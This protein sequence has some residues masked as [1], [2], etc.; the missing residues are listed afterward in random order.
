MTPLLP[1]D[2]LIWSPVVANSR[3]NRQRNAS[4]INSYEQEFNFKPEDF[5]ASR[6]KSNGNTSWLDLCCGEGNALVQIAAYFYDKGLE[7]KIHLKGV[8]LLDTFPNINEKFSCISF[9]TAAVVNYVPRQKYDL[10]TCVHGIHYLGDKLKFLEN[11]INALS[12]DGV[13]IGNL[14]LNNIIINNKNSGQWLSDF[15]KRSGI[16][17]NN[18]SR[19]IKKEGA[20][21]VNFGLHYI[22]ADD[23]SGPNYTGQEAVT[24]YYNS[25][26]V[27]L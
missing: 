4:G 20:A 19:I 25:P 26:G 1:E 12:S 8:D 2:K 21:V 17:Y 3:M 6:I 24:S 11:A 18:K 23:T 5:L 13:F 14:D 7:Q 16:T 10:I 9:E 15:F 27:A 22:G